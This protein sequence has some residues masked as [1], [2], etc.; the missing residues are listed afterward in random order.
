MRIKRPECNSVNPDDSK[1][2]KECVPVAQGIERR[3][4]DPMSW[5][6][7]T[8]CSAYKGKSDSDYDN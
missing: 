1:F 2:R 7:L 5:I 4:P 8:S 3:T 6:L